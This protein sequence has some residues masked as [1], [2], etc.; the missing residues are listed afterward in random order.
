M[1]LLEKKSG[2][3]TDTTYS[4]IEN[5]IINFKNKYSNPTKFAS[6]PPPHYMVVA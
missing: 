4:E 6:P 2:H 5:E 3:C 1:Y